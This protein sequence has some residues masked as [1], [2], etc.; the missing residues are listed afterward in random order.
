[1]RG[2]PP[3]DGARLFVSGEEPLNVGVRHCDTDRLT[4]VLYPF[5]F[6]GQDGVALTLDLKVS[7]F[8]KTPVQTQPGFR[9]LPE[10]AVDRIRLKPFDPAAVTPAEPGQWNAIADRF[11]WNEYASGCGEY[12]GQHFESA[13]ALN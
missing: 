1:L 2:F 11:R 9:V 10:E 12:D 5:R 6:V 7:G 4:R 3:R 8:G 13:W